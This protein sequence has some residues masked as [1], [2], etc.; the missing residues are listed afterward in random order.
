MGERT[1]LYDWSQTP[2]GPPEQW[3]QS[4]RTTL[5]ILLNSRF[6]MFLFWGEELTCFYNDAFRPS[7]GTNGKHPG[8]LGKRGEETWAE[9]W[10]VIK[11]LIDQVL[12]GGEA[13]WSEDQLIPFYRNGKLEDIYW[14]FS[15]S[16]VYD[17]S[18]KPAGV[19]VACME[20]TRE[21]NLVKTLQTASQ[22]F[23]DLVMQ[24]PVAI[25]VFR[26]ENFV[27]EIANDAYLPLVGKTRDEF[28]GRPLFDVLPETKPVLEPLAR[29]LIR[30]GKP[31]EKNEFEVI[32]NRYGKNETC[33]FNSLWEPLYETDGRINGFM[34]VA[35]EITE[36]VLARKRA[37][38][39]EARFKAIIQATPECIKIVD[40]D[41][42]L[43]FMNSTGLEMIESD[44]SILSN[45]SVFDMIAPEDREQWIMNHKKV[46]SGESL[47]WEF[48]IVGS[49]GSR[50]RMETHAVPLKGEA[51]V[52][53]LGVT[54]DITDR[55][56]SEE[57]LRRF[58]FMS[59][60]ASEFIGMCDLDGKPFY[61][62]KAGLEL[63]GLSETTDLST[64]SLTDFFYP[65]DALHIEND[66]L[67]NVLKEG[68]KELEIRFRHFET[69]DPIWMHYNIFRIN[70]ATGRAYGFGTISKNI[71]DHKLFTQSLALQ[72][73][74][75]TT[76]LEMSQEEIARS[77]ERLHSVFFHTQSSMFI[78]APV[79]NENGE[80]VDF[81]FVITNPTFASYVGQT[82]EALKGALGSTWFPGYLH[83]GVFDMYKKTYLTGETQRVNVH[84]D[85]D[86]HDLYLDLKS[87][88]VGDEVL[89]T[90]N[91]YSELKKTQLQL[92]KY[93]EELKRSNANLE[94]FAYAASHDLKEP[95][96]K[97]HY[98]SER[99]KSS[100]EE[101]MTA[102]ERNTFSRMELASQRMNTLIDDLLAYSQIGLRAGVMEDVD[103]DELLQHV[104]DDLDLE[105]EQKGAE[106]SVSKLATVKGYHRQ[107]QQVFQ[108]LVINALKYK[109]EEITP[110]I[111]IT[112]RRLEGKDAGMVLPAADLNKKFIEI[113]VA[114]NGI[115]FEQ[116]DAERIFNV[117]TRLHGNSEYRG[118]G[119]GLSIVRK[120]I[121]NHHG[122]IT[123]ESQ[124]GI[125]SRF[126]LFLPAE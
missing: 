76:E 105:I 45:A 54:R 58:K 5:S 1:R 93:V 51:G 126:R 59:D 97:I 75:R 113:S 71:T 104:L 94:E 52:F 72:V 43:I 13:I 83:N 42:T 16:P 100:F 79:K 112:C 17:E 61:V 73:R 9:I 107:L 66:I 19:F 20:T 98:F 40:T 35:H 116:K 92:E 124:V 41:G 111:T 46:C 85:V 33:Y 49:K 119:V 96:R 29:E 3:P 106:I 120:V 108:N 2:L 77:A 8:A 48:D 24:A 55:K 118:S 50:K 82:P 57:A 64:V 44:T 91:D 115:G 122:Y 10:P 101:R 62:N 70:D 23:R 99:L 12:S 68:S 110:M 81:R 80:V 4:L 69:G 117:F 60:N 47:A 38:E 11:P 36:Q 7:L 114:D 84:Y 95:I 34:V 67:P 89:V 102:E 109:K 22:Q 74:Q 90:F 14:T 18:G 103:L 26:G 121:E 31:V 6:P 15:Y 27:T 25:A 123:A 86:Q 65:E 78:F 125:G 63:V 21:V 88:K 39:S 28:I 30:T 37:E 87:D 53:Q 56:L 32:I